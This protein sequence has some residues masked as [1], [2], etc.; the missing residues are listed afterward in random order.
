MEASPPSCDINWIE[1]A[2]VDVGEI[3]SVHL[4][5]NQCDVKPEFTAGSKNV[6]ILFIILDMIYSE[7]FGYFFL[8][9]LKLRFFEFRSR[10]ITLK[11][12]IEFFKH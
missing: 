2:Y 1:D 4:S 8:V 3:H 5:R 6:I 7:L 11:I 10:I 12:S 9:F